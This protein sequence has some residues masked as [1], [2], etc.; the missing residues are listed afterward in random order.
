MQPDP[1]NIYAN[2]HDSMMGSMGT[3]GDLNTQ[4]GGHIHINVDSFNFT[5][6]ADEPALQIQANGIPLKSSKTTRN[7]NG[8]SGGY[9]YI[10]TTN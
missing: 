7:L 2:P 4:G 1:Q 9:V 5:S 6:K 10:N 8:G 3:I